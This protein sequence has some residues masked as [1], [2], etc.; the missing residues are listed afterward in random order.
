MLS[1]SDRI[2]FSVRL[3]VCRLPQS[4]REDELMDTSKVEQF[5]AVCPE[6]AQREEGETVEVKAEHA[7]IPSFKLED[8]VSVCSL[9]SHPV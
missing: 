2:G 4:L 9:P 1:S 3:N 8:H 5:F 7:D 6:E